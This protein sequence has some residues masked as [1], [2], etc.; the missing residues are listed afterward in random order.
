MRYGRS[1][2][3]FFFLRKGEFS[4]TRIAAL[5]VWGSCVK[6]FSGS[7]S[8]REVRI[9]QRLWAGTSLSGKGWRLQTID[10]IP[11]H[12]ARQ[13]RH[14]HSQCELGPFAPLSLKRVNTGA[15]R[16]K[17]TDSS[18]PALSS[19]LPALFSSPPL[20]AVSSSCSFFIVSCA[21][22]LYYCWH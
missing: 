12:A 17:L 15:D 14:S 22:G 6:S 13:Q 5:G 11:A 18:H 9:R 4:Q 10:L 20:K 8:G 21:A 7:A 16:E 3:V 1:G 19:R 2:E